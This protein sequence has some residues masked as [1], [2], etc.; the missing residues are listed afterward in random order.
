VSWSEVDSDYGT[1]DE[2]SYWCRLRLLAQIFFFLNSKIFFIV[3]LLAPT[4]YYIIYNFKWAPDIYKTLKFLY[5]VITSYLQTKMETRAS[6]LEELKVQ[7]QELLGPP[8]GSG[9]LVP[10]RKLEDLGGSSSDLSTKSI[11][12]GKCSLYKCSGCDA[13]FLVTPFLVFKVPI[14]NLNTLTL[15]LYIPIRIRLKCRKTLK[16]SCSAEPWYLDESKS[17]VVHGL[18]DPDTNTTF[19]CRATTV[20]AS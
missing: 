11:Q 7:I 1:G 18:L 19:A 6:T 17:V 3:C 4:P 2:K 12:G 15:S 9:E 13:R 20:S 8:I 10:I 16:A 5:K 14:F